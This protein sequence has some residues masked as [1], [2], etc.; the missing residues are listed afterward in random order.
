[1]DDGSINKKQIP[2]R[3]LKDA[4]HV[5]DQIKISLRHGIAKNFARRFRDALF[6]VDQDDKKAVEKHLQK[7]GTTWDKHLVY[8]PVYVLDRVKRYIP[9]PDELLPVLKRLFK[10]YGWNVN[11]R[12]KFNP[13]IVT[14]PIKSCVSI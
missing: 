11:K 9:P 1:M 8:D 2:S 6:I 4:F 12:F 5:M 14:Q 13:T 10:K 7:I 3:V